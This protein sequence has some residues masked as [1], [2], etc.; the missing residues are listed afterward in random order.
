MPQFRK[1]C[2]PKFAENLGM[3]FNEVDDMDRFKAASGWVNS[4]LT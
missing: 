1:D 3:L 2:L 4:Y